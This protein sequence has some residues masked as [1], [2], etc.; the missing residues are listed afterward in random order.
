[1]R[2]PITKEEAATISELFDKM[3]EAA[4][5]A[6]I[7]VMVHNTDITKLPKNF[8]RNGNRGTKWAETTVE[9]GRTL[10]NLTFFDLDRED[11]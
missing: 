11:I 1:M 5:H 8:E 2:K 10:S 4:P 3:R 7:S 6:S 9:N